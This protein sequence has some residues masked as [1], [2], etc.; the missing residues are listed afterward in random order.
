MKYKFFCIPIFGGE[1]EAS[2]N[3]FL[4]SQRVLEIDKKIVDI[5]GNAMLSFC[6]KYIAEST[7]WASS[8]QKEKVDYKN[9]LTPE[10]FEI[11]SKLRAI[12][13]LFAGEEGLPA[14]AI[15][16][17]EELSLIASLENI[18]EKSVGEIPGIGVK[19]KERY[20]S[21]IIQVLFNEEKG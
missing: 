18:T 9:K 19:K 1:E 13:K 7:S 20:A 21:R 5:N 11:F 15:F 3:Q 17:D 2:L 8:R 10:Q 6:V 16:T 14:Y 4:S 12:R